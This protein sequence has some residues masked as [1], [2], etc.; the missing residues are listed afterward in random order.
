MKAAVDLEAIATV[1]IAARLY[2]LVRFR[3]VGRDE[4]V[5]AKEETD[6]DECEDNVYSRAQP[7]GLFEGELL[8]LD[9][10]FL[11]K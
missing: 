2:K 1:P 9:R 5:V 6:A 7:G 3:E 11:H 8:S 10:L 4:L